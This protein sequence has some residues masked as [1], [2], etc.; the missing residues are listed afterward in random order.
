[1]FAINLKYLVGQPAAELSRL[2]LIKTELHTIRTILHQFAL[3]LCR[4][5]RVVLDDQKFGQRCQLACPVNDD[6]R[7]H[8]HAGS[9]CGSLRYELNLPAR[10]LP[11]IVRAITVPVHVQPL[12][13]SPFQ[14][15]LANAMGKPC[16]VIVYYVL[17]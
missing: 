5:L 15:C 9:K 17:A 7:G 1:M 4:D 11:V 13:K 3:S 16:R 2:A 14:K 6:L 12:C 8:D 10:P